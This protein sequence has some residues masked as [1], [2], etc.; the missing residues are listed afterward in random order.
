VPEL[1]TGLLPRHVKVHLRLPLHQALRPLPLRLLWLIEVTDLQE[2]YIGGN[3]ITSLPDSLG[4][5]PGMS[6]VTSL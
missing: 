6:D 1:G 2:L 4:Q 3:K 5:L